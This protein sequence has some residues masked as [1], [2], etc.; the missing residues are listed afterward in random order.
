MD[1]P[2]AADLEDREL[3]LSA[4]DL[5]HDGNEVP[6]N[7]ERDQVAIAYGTGEVVGEFSR[8][9]ASLFDG[10]LGLGLES[11]A[12]D[13]EFSFYGQMSRFQLF[14][15]GTGVCRL[16]SRDLWVKPKQRQQWKL[17]IKTVYLCCAAWGARLAKAKPSVQ[18]LCDVPGPAFDTRLLSAKHHFDDIPVNYCTTLT[19]LASPTESTAASEGSAESRQGTPRE[20]WIENWNERYQKELGNLR[21]FLE[22]KTAMAK[23]LLRLTLY[24]WFFSHIRAESCDSEVTSFLQ[25]AVPADRR[26]TVAP[27]P[28]APDLAA[29]LAALKAQQAKAAATAP[30][31]APGLAGDLAALLAKKR[32]KESQEAREVATIPSE[33]LH[34]VKLVK[35]YVPIEKNGSV[36]A[37]KTAYFGKI[38]V[39]SPEPQDFTVVFDTGSAH[40]VVPNR[41]NETKSETSIP[42]EHDG[43]VLP[44]GSVSQH[45][46]SITFGTGKVTGTFVR[47]RAC[48][49]VDSDNPGCATVN[50]VVA[51]DMSDQPFSLFHFDGILGLGLEA[52]SLGPGFSFFEQMALPVQRFSVFL[53][54]TDQGQ[55]SISFGGHD[56][57]KAASGF[58]WV[59][60][61]KPELGYWQ[62]QIHQVR[63]G[64]DVLD[65]CVDGGAIKTLHSMLSRNVLVAPNGIGHGEGFVTQEAADRAL[66]EDCR[67]QETCE[68]SREMSSDYFRP[69]PFNM[70]MPEIDGAWKLTCRSLLLPLDLQAFCEAPLG[71][72]TFILGE[73]VLRLR[74]VVA[75]V[76]D[77]KVPSADSTDYFDCPKTWILGE[78]VLRKYFSAY[79]W[80]NQPRIGFA[81]AV[82]PPPQPEGAAPAHRVTRRPEGCHG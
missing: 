14:D 69:K 58:S 47:D 79:D 72:K 17:S 46:V 48:V 20:A 56:E 36:I 67:N 5:D 26:E 53:A 24:I 57:S 31:P 42:I 65:E 60:V 13:P 25:G 68:M 77:E 35:Q 27:A 50:M 39:G 12:L 6:S 16:H 15:D 40:L 22:S 28:P 3:S 9:D 32:E 66:S 29:E 51:N 64:D 2:P 34:T 61:A 19:T 75:S 78:P 76:D 4:V 38:Q 21:A 80:K 44:R 33:P 54:R 62:V 37:Y 82:Q 45:S 55:S 74:I 18:D 81:E 63:I 10:V 70:T 30:A 43:T 11:L 23:Q 73:P 49:S 52:L 1:N 41:Y 59:P 7:S 8:E 71:P